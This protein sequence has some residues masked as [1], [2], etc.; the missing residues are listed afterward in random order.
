MGVAGSA[1]LF[2]SQSIGAKENGSVLLKVNN[3]FPVSIL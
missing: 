2:K 3:N 1:Y